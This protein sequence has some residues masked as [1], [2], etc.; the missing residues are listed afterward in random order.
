MSWLTLQG[1]FTAGSFYKISI[2][3]I[4]LKELKDFHVLGDKLEAPKPVKLVTE[5]KHDYDKTH[6]P[7]KDSELIILAKAATRSCITLQSAAI[8]F[9]ATMYLAL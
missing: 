6:I 3:Q 5:I 1:S 7:K 4:D 2:K 8:L 9:P